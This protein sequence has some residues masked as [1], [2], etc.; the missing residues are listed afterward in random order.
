M[1]TCRPDISVGTSDKDC[2]KE[3]NP[4]TVRYDTGEDLIIFIQREIVPYKSIS[5]LMWIEGIE[6]TD[7]HRPW[8]TSPSEGY[9]QDFLLFCKAESSSTASAAN[10]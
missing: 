8:S 5:T 2:A 1:K 10:V 6:H 3:S 9:Q 7:N 4:Y